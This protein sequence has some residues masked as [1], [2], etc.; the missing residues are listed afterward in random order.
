VVR[1]IEKR[2]VDVNIVNSHELVR[3]LSSFVSTNFP[4]CVYLLL[5]LSGVNS[6]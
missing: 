3:P 5:E 1:V 6:V 4:G 2:V